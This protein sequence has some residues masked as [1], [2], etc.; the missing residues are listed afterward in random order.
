MQKNLQF[1]DF[2]TNLGRP[3]G[4][5]VAGRL[6]VC[7]EEYKSVKQFNNVLATC[8]DVLNFKHTRPDK[9]TYC[10]PIEWAPFLI[11]RTPPDI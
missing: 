8:V 9:Y 11:M 3:G 2:V 5:P 1:V 6:P 10:L 4:Q 7:T